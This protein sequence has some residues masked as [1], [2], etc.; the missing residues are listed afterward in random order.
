[1]PKPTE[2]RIEGR[3]ANSFV[4]SKVLGL[5]KKEFSDVSCHAIIFAV[6]RPKEVKGEGKDSP[7][8]DHFTM[9]HYNQDHDEKN[10]LTVE[11]QDPESLQKILSA[12]ERFFEP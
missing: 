3:H 7:K 6:K 2:V 8:I 10:L 9:G 4:D 5:L 1:M 11:A 12:L